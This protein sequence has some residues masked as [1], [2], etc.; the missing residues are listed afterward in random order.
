MTRPATPVAVVVA[1]CLAA[2]LA[3]GG[4][5]ALAVLVS[6][7][8]II[9]IAR[10]VA[11]RE[12][13]SM[14]LIASV[15]AL[16][17]RHI[18][19]SALQLWLIA[20]GQAPVLF[21]DEKGYLG[22]AEELARSWHGLP[23]V[24]PGLSDYLENPSVTHAYVYAGAALFWVTGRLELV[25]KLFNSTVGVVMGLLV[26][27]TMVNLNLPGAR[28]GA[29][30]LFASPSLVLWSTLALKDTFTVL[31][32]VAVVWSTSELIRSQHS[33]L[34]IPATLIPLILMEDLRR[35]LFLLLALAWPFSLLVALDGRR[36]F[37]TFAVA[38]A[39][40]AALLSGSQAKN[41]ILDPRS[42]AAPESVRQSMAEGAQSAFVERTS[43]PSITLI[44]TPPTPPTA[45][46]TTGAVQPTISP[47]AVAA[48]AAT[49][50][51]SDAPSSSR[52]P[53]VPPSPIRA[54]APSAPDGSVRPSDDTLSLAQQ[55]LGANLRHLPL[56]AVYLLGAPFPLLARRPP[57]IALIPEMLVWYAALAFAFYA[58]VTRLRLWRGYALG[59]M[60]L[61]AIAL[62][63]SLAEGN[64]GTLVRHRSMLIPLVAVPA[65]VGFELSRPDLL[66]RLRSLWALLPRS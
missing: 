32:L 60:L 3:A 22:L 40:S 30:L 59:I 8:F 11:L 1:A 34:W 52:E 36:R 63:L 61:G 37:A 50:A 45:R 13:A 18:I 49:T 20:H 35:F 64:V 28:W 24:H 12:D 44:T 56:G 47:T 65:A 42:L 46:P 5:G 48:G 27:R 7:A 39:F 38:A 41:Y 19:A 53:T 25:L 6:T 16:L 62:V 66:A 9:A 31:L 54:V 21:E 55:S 23:P 17:G 51:P 4:W 29:L 15:L 2:A 10:K 57:E 33:L 43:V 26:Y 58:F 14:L